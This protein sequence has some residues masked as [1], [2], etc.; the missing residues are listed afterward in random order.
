M[1]ERT[2]SIEEMFSAA[3][4][5]VNRYREDLALDEKSINRNRDGEFILL[6]R[7]AGTALINLEA[8][9]A[10]QQARRRM[11]SSIDFL[12]YQ[13]ETNNYD[14][15]YLLE[16]KVYILEGYQEARAIIEY[17]MTERRLGLHIK[18]PVDTRRTLTRLIKELQKLVEEK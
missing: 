1:E 10:T 6:V 5:R 8:A 14:A 4:A 15:Y 2:I 7:D 13:D 9:V 3:N 16:G 17:K 12:D 11:K 18:R